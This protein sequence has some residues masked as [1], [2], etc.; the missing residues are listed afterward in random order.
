MKFPI[1]TAEQ[2][3]LFFLVFIRVSA[4]VVML[5]ILGDRST[6][7]RIKAGLSLLIALLVIPFVKMPAG[8][9]EDLFSLGMK[10]GGELLIGVI[11]GFAG[12]LL[13]EGIQMA[14]QLVGFQ[15]GFSIVNMIDPIASKQVSIIAEFQYL[16]AGL[17][18]LAVDGHHLLIQAISES[19][20]VVPVLGFHMTGALMQSI[21]DLTREMFVISMKIS[22][23]IIVAL[24]FAN[25]GL[26]LVA[27][28]VPQIKFSSSAFPSRSPSAFSASALPP[29]S[30]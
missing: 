23:P 28:T 4:I 22:A 30:S 2:A 26:G 29:P 8:L 14:G 7:V 10:M 5:P 20:T 9:S 15:M 13:F 6:P 3:E 17:L 12:R 16:M 11:L 18:F 19:Y 25:I 24:V 1:I 21:V 27:R